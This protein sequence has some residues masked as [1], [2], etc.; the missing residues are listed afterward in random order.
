MG[1]QLDL[2][3]LSS[4]NKQLDSVGIFG[5]DPEQND[6]CLLVIPG[7]LQTVVFISGKKLELI[8][9]HQNTPSLFF[10]SDKLLPFL[11]GR[12]P[13]KPYLV[14]LVLFLLLNV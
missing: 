10:F 8:L 6:S 11:Y 1:A 2:W 4:S 14:F 5:V 3:F 13:A 12:I 7:T 9:K